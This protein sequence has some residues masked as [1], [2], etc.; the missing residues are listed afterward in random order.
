MVFV[1]KM[2]G[3][4]WKP[5]TLISLT[6]TTKIKILQ[7][8]TKPSLTLG[9]LKKLSSLKELLQDFGNLRS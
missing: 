4:V 5:I 1:K 9:V 3:L 8:M 2:Y 7:N 6:P